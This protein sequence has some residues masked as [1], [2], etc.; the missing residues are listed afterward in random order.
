MPLPLGEVAERC[1]DG[2]GTVDV[3]FA[4]SVTFGDSSPSGR[5]KED[6]CNCVICNNI[7]TERIRTDTLR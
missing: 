4:L 5:A 3:L 6:T 7:K 2:E 1:E